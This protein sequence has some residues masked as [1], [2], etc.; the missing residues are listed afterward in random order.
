MKL[1]INVFDNLINKPS[2]KFFL[3]LFFLKNNLYTIL[4]NINYIHIFL[5]IKKIFAIKIFKFNYRLYNN[6]IIYFIL[7]NILI[8]VIITALILI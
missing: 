1:F 5:K 6:F 2:K 7:L 4:K 8:Q 3:N